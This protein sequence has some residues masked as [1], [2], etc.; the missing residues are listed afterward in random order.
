MVHLFPSLF[1]KKTHRHT[2]LKIEQALFVSNHLVTDHFPFLQNVVAS[3]NLSFV[4]RK[5]HLF[6]EQTKT[7]IEQDIIEFHN[8]TQPKIVIVWLICDSVTLGSQMYIYKVSPSLFF[9]LR[10][11]Y[12]SVNSTIFPNSIVRGIF[13]ARH[14]VLNS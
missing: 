2:R 6:L 8:E 7:N 9:L 3:Q 13:F 4:R 11:R 5:I 1:P 14:M 10:L 12:R